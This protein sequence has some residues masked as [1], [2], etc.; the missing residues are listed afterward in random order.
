MDTKPKSGDSGYTNG[1]KGLIIEKC[2]P[3]ANVVGTLDELQASLGVVFELGIL[4]KSNLNYDF[5][6]KVLFGIGDIMG[7]IYHNEIKSKSYEFLTT[8]LEILV[9]DMEK[10][11]PPLS[12]FILPL[13]SLL[14]SQIHLARAVC[15]RAERELAYYYFTEENSDVV[16][17][18]IPFL[19]RLNKYLFTLARYAKEITND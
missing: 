7:N 6:E 5:L 18:A 2:S 4:K 11:L 10:D 8:R 16:F 15:R 3:F 14:V 1:P 12:G 17:T 9:N 19:N 13:G